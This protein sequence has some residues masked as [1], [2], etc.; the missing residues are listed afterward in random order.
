MKKF[1][2]IN[3]KDIID[4]FKKRLNFILYVLIFAIVCYSYNLDS[5]TV[6]F[7]LKRGV[8][9]EYSIPKN[10]KINK[11]EI[12]KKLIELNLKYSS[13]ET[14]DTSFY[15][16]VDTDYKIINQTLKIALAKKANASSKDTFNKISN[17]IFDTYKNSK[18]IELRSLNDIYSTP[19]KAFNTALCLLLISFFIWLTILQI[20]YKKESFILIVK[21][22]ILSFFKKIKEDFIDLI[23]KTKE[24]GILY[25]LK[26]I[27]LD[28]NKD[29]EETDFTKE[30][31]TTIIFVIVFVALIRAF[32]GELRWIP[33][34]SM[35][36]T[37]L[38]HDRVFVEKLEYPKK[39]IKRG[40]I[41]VFY[42]P[43]TQLSNSIPA[44]IARYT[45]IFCKDIAFIKRVV[46]LPNEKFEIKQDPFSNE[47]RVF[48]N[49]KPL[50]EPYIN[51]KTTWTPCSESMYCGPFIIPENSYFM[52]GDNRNNSQDSRFWGFLDGS[53]VIGRANFMFF[54]FSRI[55]LLKDKYLILDKAKNKEVETS[56]FILNRYE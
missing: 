54:P 55:N 51:S 14:E 38:E 23:K 41:L 8:I 33:S 20:F 12:N 13:I 7:V 2:F 43:E 29:D 46:G 45:G 25:L 15:E 24:K 53:R 56:V 30:I 1:N 49:D 17:Y 50:N 42:P 39:E 9:L 36:E 5:Q 10:T 32:I 40:D 52:M 26:R 28:D 3:I 22:N 48:I 44:L 6:N 18:L 47:Y 11:D 4:F 19:Y 21:N 37:I 34:G 35:R 27:L 16:L 31:I